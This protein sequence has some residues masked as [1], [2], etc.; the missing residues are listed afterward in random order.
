MKV[1]KGWGSCSLI[2]EEHLGGKGSRGLL[3]GTEKPCHNVQKTV[4][5]SETKPPFETFHWGHLAGGARSSSLCL[6]GVG[7]EVR[8]HSRKHAV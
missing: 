3:A 6:V 7:A 2:F 5:A 4:P 8:K 1:E